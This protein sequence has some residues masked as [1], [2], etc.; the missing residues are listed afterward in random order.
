MQILYRNKKVK[1]LSGYLFSYFKGNIVVLFSITAFVFLPG[2]PQDK[3]DDGVKSLPV[4][5]GAS[6][7][8][9][10]FYETA[11][12]DTL[13]NYFNCIVSESHMKW[14][15]L[16]PTKGNFD[17]TDA[18]KVVDFAVTNGMKVRGHVLLWHYQLPAWITTE[19]F[20]DLDALL[21]N[22]INTVV[23][24]YKGKIFAWDV[25]N[26]IIT[27]G[28]S[29]NGSGIPGL[30]NNDKSDADKSIWS[31]DSDDDS[32]IIKAF[33]YAHAADPEAKLFINDN[34]NY[35]SDSDPLMDYWN[36]LQADVLYNYIKKWK[37][38]GIPVH[39]VGMQLH[40]DAEYPPDYTMIENDIIR[41]G[42]LG[43]EV[44]FTEIDVRIKNPA[45]AAEISK[46]HAVY[47]KLAELMAKYPRIVTAFVTWGVTDKYSWIPSYFSGYGSALL[48]DNNYN[49]KEAYTSVE[50]ILGL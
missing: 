15:I 41:Y 6:V 46:Q 14:E 45:D 22:H 36:G 34:N 21:Q 40:I 47:Q 37:E 26:E 1:Q 8:P 2:C 32:L 13:K 12:S 25:A 4:I 23:G 31:D 9:D 3:D 50:N 42:A 44:H 27:S 49:P 19:N 24:L 33:Q 43:L 16:Q 29:F 39:G 38:S 35:G 11:Y 10:F 17:F 5:F 28:E 30:R 20:S 18:D 48:F 7:D